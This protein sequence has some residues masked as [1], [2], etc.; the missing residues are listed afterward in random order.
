MFSPFDPT[1][2]K[3]FAPNTPAGLAGGPSI[4]YFPS[5]PFFLFSREMP[6]GQGRERRFRM[7][8]AKKLRRHTSAPVMPLPLPLPLPPAFCFLLSCR[9]RFSQP[10]QAVAF[11]PLCPQKNGRTNRPDVPSKKQQ[12]PLPAQSVAVPEPVFTYRPQSPANASNLHSY[13]RHG[14]LAGRCS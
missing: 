8:P 11:P 9:N 4:L 14:K 1:G 7:P 6:P 2:T 3:C 10:Q 13:D 12:K 5:R